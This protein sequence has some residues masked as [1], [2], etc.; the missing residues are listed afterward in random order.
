[1]RC[2]LN[3]INLLFDKLT[4]N[5]KTSSRGLKK[6]MNCKRRKLFP[7]CGCLFLRQQYIPRKPTQGFSWFLVYAVRELIAWERAEFLFL[8]SVVSY[9]C[10][11]TL[12]FHP[13][14]YFYTYNEIKDDRFTTRYHFISG[15]IESTRLRFLIHVDYPPLTWSNMIM[16]AARIKLHK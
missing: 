3:S 4:M 2:L 12:G 16:G 9:V 6:I 8:Q 14:F 11:S 1:M 5:R 7:Y 10:Y 15:Y 13:F